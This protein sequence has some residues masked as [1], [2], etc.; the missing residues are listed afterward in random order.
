MLKKSPYT[1]DG[2]FAG[3]TP[4][5]FENAKKLRQNMTDAEITLWVYLKQS[6]EGYKFRRQHPLGNYIIDFYCHKAKMV[7]EL[8]G[9]IHHLPEVMQ[10]DKLRQQYL[11][12]SGLKV[13]RFTNKEVLHNV[14]LVL[15]TINTHLIKEINSSL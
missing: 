1:K 13:I 5:I 11:E 15:H 12:E 10:N 8:D 9:S 14:H 4:A 2:M 3:A 7:V 6:P